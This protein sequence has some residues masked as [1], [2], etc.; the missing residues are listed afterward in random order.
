MLS[1]TEVQFWV[2]G[3][4]IKTKQ[5]F[6]KTLRWFWTSISV[7]NKN[8]IICAI[9]CNTSDLELAKVNTKVGKQGFRSLYIFEFTK[10]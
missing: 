5:H 2:F 10:K 8:I 1:F 6:K 4:K 7:K 9:K 3:C